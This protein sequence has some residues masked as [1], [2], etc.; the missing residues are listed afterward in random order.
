MSR[1]YQEIRPSQFITTFGPGS[2][3]ETGSGPVVLKALDT[4]FNEIRREPADFEI[5]D[6]RFSRLALDGARIARLPTN[7]EL[8]LPVDNQIYRTERFP[9]WALC[10]QHRPHQI[11][12]DASSGCPQCPGQQQW[13][14]RRKAGRE[15][16][17]FVRACESGHL[18]EVDWYGMVHTSRSCRTDHYLWHGGGRALRHVRIECPRCNTSVSFGQAYA[19]PWSCTGRQPELGGQPPGSVRCTQRARIIQRGAANLR[20]AEVGT[21]LTIMDM[22]ARLHSVLSDRALLAALGV[23]HRV[24][25]LN[26][27][28]FAAEVGRLSLTPEATELLSGTAWTDIRSALEQ[29]LDPGHGETVSLRDQEFERLH[30]AGAHGAPAVPHPHRGSPPLFEIRHADVRD[31]AGLAGRMVLR[32]VPVSRLRIVMVQTG[33]RRL[34]PQ[35]G[36][37]VSTRF[38]WNGANWYPGV[39]LFGEG[40]F[41]EVVDGQPPL[42]GSRVDQWNTRYSVAG[43]PQTHPVHVW[44]H[45]LSHRLMRTLAVDSGYSSAAIRERVYLKAGH[46]AVAGSGLLLYTAQPGGDGTLGGLISLVDRFQ[47]VL[48]G[49][50]DDADT[51]SND[52]LCCEAVT[53]GADGAACYACLHASETSCE[54]RNLGLDRLLLADNLP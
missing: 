39:E 54:H 46:G 34:N 50:L 26:Q 9:Y 6:D 41:L 47:D 21:A 3:V 48:A 22:P 17:R 51:C 20:L 52:P 8:R 28:T 36:G 2:V 30:H 29:L 40:V 32:V 49:A 37:I 43:D 24:G 25:M 19:R 16:I 11:L 13:E 14:R 5:V 42:R 53:V 12:Y 33:Y 38:D 35:T 15:A 44:W 27:T 4:V 10:A 1:P 23:L 31:L 45:T 18:D 7:A